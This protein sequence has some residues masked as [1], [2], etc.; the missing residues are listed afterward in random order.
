[1]KNPALWRALW[2]IQK[3]ILFVSF[4]LHSLAARPSR[5]ITWEVGVAE[6]S[7]LVGSLAAV[8][9]GARSS[10]LYRNRFYPRGYG[11]QVR[12]LKSR[13]LTNAWALLVGPWWLGRSLCL[14]EG[15]LYVGALG[16]L[17]SSIDQ[18]AWEM[19]FVRRRGL[20][21]ACFLTGTDIRSTALSLEL[22][23]EHGCVHVGGILGRAYP[24]MATPEYEA[25]KKAL[26]RAIDANAGAVFSLASAQASY[27]EPT[28]HPTVYAFPDDDFVADFTK[29][30]RTEPLRLLHAPSSPL[31]KGT[32]EV[33]QAIARLRADGYEFEYT[34]LTETS[35]ERV[36]RELDRAHIVLNN[37]FSYTPGVFGVEALARGCVM[38]SSA[39]E[40][41][42]PGLPPGSDTAWIRTPSSH[43]YETLVDLITHPEKLRP[44]AERGFAFAQAHFSEHAA[45]QQIVPI[46]DAARAHRMRP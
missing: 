3:V 33:S 16:Y 31:L 10:V 15:I 34:E 8:I 22:E 4:G 30:E 12:A 13:R 35:N 27:L 40:S 23:L 2:G 37:F 20:A 45:R 44:Q 28:F 38:L 14:A 7:S 5:K 19:N 43:I 25:S 11:R 39:S 26:A 1:M 41:L 24:W 9:P 32:A 36:L 42:E 29:F 18:R 46:L 21:V 6:I 17:V